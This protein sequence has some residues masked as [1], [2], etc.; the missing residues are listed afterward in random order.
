M[1][2]LYDFDGTLTPYS[3]PQ[4]EIIKKCGYTI[5]QFMEKVTKKLD[6][7]SDLCQIYFKEL[8]QIMED[9]KQERKDENFILGAE[10]VE[11]NPGVLEFLRSLKENGDKQYIISSGMKVYLDHTKIAK[12]VDEIFGVTF[13]YEKGNAMKI[14]KSLNDKKKVSIIKQVM[15]KNHLKDGKEVIY[16]GDGL[17]DQYAFEYVK[18]NGGIAVFVYGD[19]KGKEICEELKRKNKINEGFEANFSQGSE[20]TKFIQQYQKEQQAQE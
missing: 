2:I 16:F 11:Y 13:S 14:E 19:D 17:T 10:K 9:K 12:L 3:V 1:I 4:Y 6:S 5:S 18:E 15:H 8:F 7:E 20:L